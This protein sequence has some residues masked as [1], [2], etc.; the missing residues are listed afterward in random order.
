MTIPYLQHSNTQKSKNTKPSAVNEKTKI[1]SQ[2]KDFQLNNHIDET[3]PSNMPSQHH[4]KPPSPR[5]FHLSRFPPK[6]EPRGRGGGVLGF[7]MEDLNVRTSVGFD[8][9]SAVNVR[10][11]VDDGLEGW[12]AKKEG[13][14]LGI[15]VLV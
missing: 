14:G 11:R 15:R 13:D 9:V 8:V 1:Q 4:R 12:W 7:W 5:S 2:N 3:Q 10:K 6:A